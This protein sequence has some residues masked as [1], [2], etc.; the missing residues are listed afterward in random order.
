MFKKIMAIVLVVALTAT[1]SVAGT[2]AYLSDT[3]EDVNVMTMGNVK[4]KQHEYER[5]IDANGNYETVTTNRGTGYKLV[6][7]TQNKP[8]YPAVGAVTGWD[9]TRV[10]YDQFGEGHE[11]GVMDVLAGLNN[12]QDKFV[13]VENTGNSDAY[14][15]TII[16]FE[17]G[18]CTV[19][20]WDALVKTSSHTFWEYT[21]L[22]ETVTIGDNAYVIVECNYSKSDNA[23]H[24]DGIVHPGDYTYNNLAQIYMVPEATNE[25]VEKLDGNGNGTYDILVLSQAVQTA[26]FS[27]AQT[28][29]DTAFGDVTAENAK[30]WFGSIAIEET[31]TVTAEDWESIDFNQDNARYVLSG[32]F[33]GDLAITIPD[34]LD[35]VY[36]ASGANFAGETTVTI[37]AP[38]VAHAYSSL[39]AERKGNVTVTGFE[40]ETLNV[41]AY[42]NESVTI[43]NNKVNSL[44][45]IGG[46][47]ELIID[48]NLV[49]GNFGKY[50]DGENQVNE[51]GISL[52]ICDYELSITN[53]IITDTYSHSIGINGRQG[54][55][56]SDWGPAGAN[57][58]ITSFSGNNIT[59][60]TTYKTERGALKIWCDQV[61]APYAT[62]GHAPN[63]A[64]KALMSSILSDSSNV[65]KLSEGHTI[66]NIFDYKTSDGK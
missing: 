63:A 32:D 13:F 18:Q 8:L 33:T 56:A 25:D 23:R 55:A 30:N 47:F 4:I 24:P 9:S 58:K 14:V 16:A 28:A 31:V 12:V 19:E 36:D 41:L 62:S 17:A 29:L 39:N 52:R 50:T 7:F 46:N 57:N 54:E 61:Y 3:D 5:G 35:Q 64:A 59:L 42:N 22:D 45:V 20:E 38:G 43:S 15:R 6:D 66:F 51:Y 37:N 21:F 11:L 49:D 40:V 10:F 65:F 44:S 27:N 34:G 1:I 48:N 60:N 26:G 2:M 53:N